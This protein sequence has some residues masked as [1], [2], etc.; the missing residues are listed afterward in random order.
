M[1]RVYSDTLAADCAQLE[2]AFPRT[3]VKQLKCLIA[4]AGALGN[5]V[6][7]VL[8]LLGVGAV[9][10][11]DPDRVEARNLPCSI[12]FNGGMQSGAEKAEALAG[13]AQGIFPGTAWISIPSEI[14]D[15]GFQTIAGCD[16]MFS[17]VDSDLARLEIAYIG[18]ALQIPVVDG[19]LSGQNYANGRVTFFPGGH[20][21]ACFACM[22]SSQ[23]RAQLLRECRG[24]VRPCTA[25]G[26]G[27]S[28]HLPS[29]PTMAGIVAG[30]QVE[31]G[32]RSVLEDPNGRARS[33]EIGIYPSYYLT[34]VEIRVSASCPFHE[35]DAIR[36]MADPART[37]AEMM[38]AAGSDSILLDWPICVSARC[39]A[40]GME[41][42]PNKRIAWLRR[43]GR[44]PGCKG[45]DILE[46]EILR[47]VDLGSRW[48]RRTP[49]ELELPPHHVYQC[50]THRVAP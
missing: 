50:G 27:A 36:V 10:L 37:F 35:H 38:D 18:K 40:C 23:R 21:H 6:T 32:L 43:F 29:T 13:A 11:V 25:P 20:D 17:C 33:L 1:R 4:G 12:F 5:E 19:G 44:C 15:V 48:S 30:M 22:L 26:R 8:G 47:A 7:R 34:E 24:I 14:A 31:V 9:T 42:S 3:P 46:L 28:D 16:L 45:G 41:W 49:A 2:T 39:L